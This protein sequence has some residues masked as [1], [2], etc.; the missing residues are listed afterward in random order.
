MFASKKCHT[1]NR[2]KYFA[3]QIMNHQRN[4]K[5]SRFFDKT[6]SFIPK[7]ATRLQ[8]VDGTR[9]QKCTCHVHQVI[10]CSSR[11]PVASETHHRTRQAKYFQCDLF[12]PKGFQS[13]FDQMK[14]GHREKSSQKRWSL[15]CLGN[16]PSNQTSQVLS[17]YT[18][19]ALQS[20]DSKGW[21]ECISRAT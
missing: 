4:W 10:S 18:L 2:H 15:G 7:P 13:H 1:Y 12:W 14:K 20:A 16:T 17:V 21:L 19:I 9:W 6:I 8:S 11:H 3:H 5:S